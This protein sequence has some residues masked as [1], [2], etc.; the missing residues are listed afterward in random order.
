MIPQHADLGT[1]HKYIHAVAPYMTN[2]Y[3]KTQNKRKLKSGYYYWMIIIGRLKNLQV[4]T[5][6]DMNQ[7]FF[8]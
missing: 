5:I 6:D 2:L 7:G 1:L 8:Y 3:I 4:L